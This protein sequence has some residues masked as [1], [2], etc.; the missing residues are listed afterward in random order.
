MA[1]RS[2]LAANLLSLEINALRRGKQ[3]RSDDSVKSVHCHV[4]TA[5]ALQG[6]SAFLDHP[7][8][9]SHVSGLFARRTDRWP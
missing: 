1:E 8:W 2:G 9:G 6:K 7:V 4:W 3:A 5:P